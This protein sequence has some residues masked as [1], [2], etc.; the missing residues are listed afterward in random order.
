MFYPLSVPRCA[1][2]VMAGSCKLICEGTLGF[3]LSIPVQIRETWAGLD[4]M[5]HGHKDMEVKFCFFEVE[6]GKPE[7]RVHYHPN[8]L[9]RDR[10]TSH[11]DRESG[12]N[13][14]N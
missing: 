11:P 5:K 6:R 3:I 13:G 1:A 14:E 4:D 2:I 7:E 8:S 10:N 12:V 9:G